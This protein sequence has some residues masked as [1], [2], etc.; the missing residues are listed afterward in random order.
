MEPIGIVAL[1]SPEIMPTTGGIVGVMGFSVSRMLPLTSAAG[2]K[3]LLPAC[4]ASM[5]Q[6][7][8]SIIVTVLD[9]VPGVVQMAGV[10][11]V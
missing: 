1:A 2:L 11:E 10:R 3:L 5:V 8:L 4:E 9:V 7:P 6:V